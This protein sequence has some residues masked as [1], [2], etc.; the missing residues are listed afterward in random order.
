MRST[1]IA[2]F[3]SLA[4]IPRVPPHTPPPPKLEGQIVCCT[5]CWNKAD[6][7]TTPY[8]TSADLVKASNCVAKGDPTLLA[9]MNRE[10]VPTFYQLEDG[11]Y[12]KAG[13]TWLELVGSRVEITGL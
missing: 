5:D 2:L 6:R 13:K 4:F 11:G 8:G 3:L 9:V 1:L 7:K 10:G 12:K